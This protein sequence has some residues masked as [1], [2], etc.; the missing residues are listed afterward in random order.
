MPNG[1]FRVYRDAEN[2][3]DIRFEQ[4]SNSGAPAPED[5]LE[6]R[7]EIDRTLT[8]VQMLFPDKDSQFEEYF[9]PLLSLAQVGLVGD[10]ADPKLAGRALATLKDEIVSREGGRIKNQYMKKLGI[11]A[12]SMALPI[13]VIGAIL[14]YVCP[15]LRA[16]SGF[17]LLWSGC[18]A[19]VWL[20]F[21]ARKVFLKFEDLN[22]VEKDRLDPAIRLV[23]AGLLTMII[24]LLLS[25]KAV[26]IN[27]GGVTTENFT[28]SIEIC[29]LIGLLCGFSEQALSAKVSKHA[30]SILELG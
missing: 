23:F 14:H 24:G 3:S 20:S 1:A 4:V 25:T 10:S 15:E 7:D 28:S 30:S 19:G 17:L 21:G 6:L 9:R 5:Q 12:L 27:L 11:Y 18:M 2:P 13:A 16:I 8:V 26:V 29:L 22:I